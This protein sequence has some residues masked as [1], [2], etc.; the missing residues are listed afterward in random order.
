MRDKKDVGFE[1]FII[2]F[3]L[4]VIVGLIA[5]LMAMHR[6]AEYNDKTHNNIEE[7]CRIK[8][9]PYQVFECSVKEKNIKSPTEF[10]GFVLC[11]PEK[12][13]IEF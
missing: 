13:L 3:V 10:S 9:Y 8:C 7:T 4:L 1:L 11:H 2:L 5:F 12:K 6:N